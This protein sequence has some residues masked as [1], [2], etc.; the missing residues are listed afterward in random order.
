MREKNANDICAMLYE[1]YGGES[2]KSQVFCYGIN[3]SKRV[4]RTWKIVNEVVVQDLTEP[5]KTSKK[6]VICCIQVDVTVSDK[7]FVWKY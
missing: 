6:C 5:M 4:A 7:L 1:T 2:A 3:G